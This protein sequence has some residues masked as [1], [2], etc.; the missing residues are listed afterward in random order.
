MVNNI[1]DEKEA[2]DAIPKYQ[3][4]KTA[5][6][7]VAVNKKS[8]KLILKLTLKLNVNIFTKPLVLSFHQKKYIYA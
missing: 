8:K 5:N 1:S 3:R 7:Q 4:N 6:L 2:V